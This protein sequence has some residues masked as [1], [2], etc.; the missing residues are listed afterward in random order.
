MRM[1]PRLR[2]ERTL[3]ALTHKKSTRMVQ[4]LS[5]EDSHIAKLRLVLDRCRE[6]RL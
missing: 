1:G 6:P 5:E 3:M 2:N 4:T